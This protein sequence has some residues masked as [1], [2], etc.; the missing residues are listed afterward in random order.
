MT[1]RARVVLATRN[2]GKAREISAIYA[3][4]D[5]EFVTVEA[6][7]ALGALPEDGETY[8]DNAVS[9]ARAAAAATGC[10]A[11]ADDSGI[12]IDAFDGAPGPR[13][14]RFLGADA[15]DEDRNTHILTLLR[16]V[17]E[18][19]RTAR[20]RA[21]V[22][23]ALPDGTVHVA[24]GTCEGRIAS[25]PRGGGGFGYD[26]VFVAA[27]DGRTMAELSFEEK[28]QISH[29]ARA[30]RA[31]EPHLRAALAAHREEPRTLDANTTTGPR[32]AG[33]STDEPRA[34][35]RP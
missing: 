25:A 3:H 27:A 7:P 20:Y 1:A 8:A 10:V 2:V 23:I 22:A 26:P 16:D 24:E 21:A 29:R 35:G 9:K 4:L 32:Q 5:A 18:G 12:E 19:R 34:G 31:A 28:N 33:R 30:L 17:P 15:S 13:S 6:W 14:R 11:V